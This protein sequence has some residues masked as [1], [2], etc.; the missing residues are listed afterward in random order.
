MRWGRLG[1]GWEGEG[2]QEIDAILVCGGCHTIFHGRD[3]G[4]SCPKC[5]GQMESGYAAIGLLDALEDSEAMNILMG[6]SAADAAI[7]AIAEEG[8]EYDPSFVHPRRLVKL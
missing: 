8:W 1:T 3:M 4:A 6:T 2:M 7:E 5:Q